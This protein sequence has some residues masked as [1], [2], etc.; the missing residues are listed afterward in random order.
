[1][2]NILVVDD[3]PNVRETVV[4]V[5][6]SLCGRGHIIDQASDG[7]EALN[8]FKKKKH[9][10]VISDFNMPK[11]NGHELAL[12]VRQENPHQPFIA[13]TGKITENEGPLHQAGVDTV[14]SKPFKLDE[15]AQAVKKAL[16]QKG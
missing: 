2:A 7:E 15:L 16:G 5:I 10:L 1:M 4:D 14:L 12:A 3:D 6:E 13:M 8:L 11:M 9:A